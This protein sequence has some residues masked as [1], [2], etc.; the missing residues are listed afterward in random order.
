MAKKD[1]FVLTR[2]MNGDVVVDGV[3]T[4]E[5]KAE[6]Y[7]LQLAKDF[8]IEE[9]KIDDSEYNWEIHSEEVQ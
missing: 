9:D 1:V 6:D 8:G 2:T 5:K 4:T 3:F 7:K